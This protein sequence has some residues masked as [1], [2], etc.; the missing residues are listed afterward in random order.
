MTSVIVRELS[1]GEGSPKICIPI[2]ENNLENIIKAAEQ[3]LDSPAD[4]VEWRADWFEYL[5]DFDKT[6][7][8]L[9]ILREILKDIPIIFT[10]RSKNEG[11]E[12]TVD[13]A[14][15]LELNKKAIDTGCVDLIDVEVL[16]FKT[17]AKELIDYSHRLAVKVIASHH[18]FEKTPEKEEMISKLEIM[19]SFGADILKIAVMPKT[20][21]D[22]E[23]LLAVSDKIEKPLIAISMSELGVKSRLKGA[24]TFGTVGKA[25]APGQISA[26][27]LKEKLK[28]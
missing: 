20:Y 5:L 24:V 16:S 26:Y 2:A 15:Y 17:V 19:E 27:E 8:V 14:T 25:S 12:K 6:K 7:E 11:G 23:S 3:I 22:V 21:E 10:I 28:G 4:L 18:D 1:I 9:K 13:E